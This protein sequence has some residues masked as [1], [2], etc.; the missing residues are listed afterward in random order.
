MH[1]VE[2]FENTSLEYVR[3]EMQVSEVATARKAAEDV[4]KALEGIVPDSKNATTG[5]ALEWIIGTLTEASA[6]RNG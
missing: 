1:N 6:V 2:A 3:A 5:V 4:V